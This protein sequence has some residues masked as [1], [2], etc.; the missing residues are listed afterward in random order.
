M[1]FEGGEAGGDATPTGLREGDDDG[2]GVTAGEG[3]NE[4]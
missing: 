2:A 4:L 1:V 3:E